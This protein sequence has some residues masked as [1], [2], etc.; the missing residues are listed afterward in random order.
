M[1]SGHRVDVDVVLDLARQQVAV[2]EAHLLRRALQVDIGPSAFIELI[3]ALQARVRGGLRGAV[4]HDGLG[5]RIERR[6]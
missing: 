3:A 4:V 2:L 1:R 5:I 6:V